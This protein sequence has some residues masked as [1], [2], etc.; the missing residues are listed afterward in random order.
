MKSIFSQNAGM[1]LELETDYVPSTNQV[2]LT[3]TSVYEHS[4][5][6]ND[7]R[8]LIQLNLSRSELRALALHL[9]LQLDE[10]FGLGNSDK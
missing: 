3:I 9:G 4:K 1:T 2:A 8:R 7:A 6:P 10:I 5:T